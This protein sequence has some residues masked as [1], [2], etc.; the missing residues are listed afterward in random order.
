[1][2][3]FFKFAAIA[4]IAA[5]F[6]G[7]GNEKPGPEPGPDTPST[8]YTQDLKFTLDLKEVDVD[9][10]KVVVEHNGTTTDTWYA[11]A[12]TETN[13]DKAISD[14][15]AE[16]GVKLQNKT[17]YTVTV[18]NLEP[19]TTYTFVAVGVT[20]DGKTY[21][22][23][24]TLEFTTAAET[25]SEGFRVNEAWTVTYSGA[26]EF[27][28]Q[29][30]EHSIT[31]TS[32]DNSN[33]YFFSIWAKAD[34][35]EYGV[36]ELIEYDYQ[37]FNEELPKYNMTWDDFLYVGTA[38]YPY[39][40]LNPG[41]YIAMAIGVGADH[42]LSGLYA[43]SE[44]IT[45]TEAEMTEGY[46]AWLGNW[47]LTGANGLTQNVTFSKKVANKTYAMTGYEGEDTEGLEVI[48]NWFEE[49]QCWAIYNQSLGKYDFGSYGIGE[50]WFVGEDVEGS[51]YLAEI[52]ICI[53]GYMD[54]NGTRG[55]IG[56]EETWENEDG[57]TGTYAVN[58]MLFLAKFDQGVSYISGTFETGYPT[59]PLTITPASTPNAL[60]VEKG[61]TKSIKKSL[62]FNK[63]YKVFATK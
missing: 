13:I 43:V 48:V 38:T 42:Q 35:D 24:A 22:E 46:A 47:T 5:A 3:K 61:L 20:T 60:S 17:R 11:F 45:I 36:E 33:R 53:G 40:E 31:V 49:E 52:P 62:P 63:E 8:G 21:G 28:G 54:E 16:E 26:Q 32:T 29:L 58:D 50:I 59:F 27:Q 2:K 7:C 25:A 41:E 15:L 14:A 9:Q 6:V 57:S 4:A 39:E 18:K 56:Y 23:P 37:Y 10:A 44:T 30:F 51:F 19:E 1:M 55:A 34:V 12:T